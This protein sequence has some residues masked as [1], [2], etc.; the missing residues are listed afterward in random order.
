MPDVNPKTGTRRE[1]AA[2]TRR[3]MIAAAI[4]VFTE[5]GYAGA[6]MPEIAA[7]AGVAVQ[8]LY[9][10]F[11]TKAELL[12]ACYEFAV[13]GPERVPPPDQPFW[14][15][16][17]AAT[18]GR[19]AL[20]AFVGGNTAI[21]ER[22]SAIEEVARAALREPDAVAVVTHNERLRRE[23]YREVVLSLSKR[24]GLRA[25]LDAE[26]ATDILL[27]LAGP[28][29]FLTLQRCGWDVAAYQSW[30]TDALASQLLGC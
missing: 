10:G 18:S 13:L 16:I 4:E 19:Q 30:L 12:Q 8:T 9:L 1:R 3:R 29:P 25:E 28:G 7:R 21:A 2:A 20:A 26:R 6:R 5:A 27:L 14:S 15:E 24:F 11:H 22:V 17:A 23:G